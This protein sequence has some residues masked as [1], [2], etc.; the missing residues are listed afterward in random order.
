M[1]SIL[2]KENFDFPGHKDIIVSIPEINIDKLCDL[3]YFVIDNEYKP[4]DESHRKGIESLCILLENWITWLNDLTFGEAVFLPFDLS[5]EYL[6]GFY[7]TLSQNNTLVVFYCYSREMMGHSISPTSAEKINIKK[8]TFGIQPNA[9]V[10][11]KASFIGDIRESIAGIIS[12][13][14]EVLQG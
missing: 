2:Y 5:D 8:A 3:Y 13:N 4:A 12:S 1:L 9:L 6:G 7:V 14:A 10:T 11:D